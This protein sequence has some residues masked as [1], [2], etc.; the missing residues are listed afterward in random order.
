M[1]LASAG[2]VTLAVATLGWHGGVGVLPGARRP[3]ARRAPLA[4]AMG[5]RPPLTEEER[6][7]LRLP[8]QR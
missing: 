7:A 8:A 3:H 5:E 4:V 6:Q 2:I 1:S